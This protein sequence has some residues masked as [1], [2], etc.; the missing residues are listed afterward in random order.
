LLLDEESGAVLGSAMQLA[1]GAS[2]TARL[3]DGRARLRVVGAFK[4]AE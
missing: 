1:D 4:P 2:V 3:H